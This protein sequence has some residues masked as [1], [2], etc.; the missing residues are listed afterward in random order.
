MTTFLKL[1]WQGA[2]ALW[3]FCVPTWVL[4]NG[5]NAEMIG[6]LLGAA[7][8]MVLPPYIL[9]KLRVKK[10]SKHDAQRESVR[11]LND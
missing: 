10:D 1:W 3:V 9:W 7:L 4:I 8:I 5:V 2:L 6:F 11:R